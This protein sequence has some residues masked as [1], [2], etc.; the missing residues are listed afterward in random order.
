MVVCFI[1]LYDRRYP[2]Q[3][4]V[5]S[6][7]CSED[8]DVS[9]AYTDLVTSSKKTLDSLLELQEVCMH[10]LDSVIVCCLLVFCRS[11]TFVDFY[12]YYLNMDFYRLC[13]RRTPRLINK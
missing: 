2:F 5:K 7:F 13:L 8:E 4:P 11:A 3:E 9:T 12:Y 10:R 1:I 6:L